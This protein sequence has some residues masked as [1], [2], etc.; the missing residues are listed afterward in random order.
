MLSRVRFID[1]IHE[2]LMNLNHISYFSSSNATHICILL[3]DE[4]N[5]SYEKL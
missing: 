5:V 4:D 1:V 3:F 2:C